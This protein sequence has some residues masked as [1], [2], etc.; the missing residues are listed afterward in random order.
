MS[1]AKDPLRVRLQAEAYRVA[2]RHGRMVVAAAN[3]AGVDAEV[4]FGLLC[5]ESMGRA[6]WANRVLE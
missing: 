1:A 3:R 5:L 2:R 4:M 6:S